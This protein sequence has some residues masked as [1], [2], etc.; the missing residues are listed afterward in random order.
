MP[1]TK[2]TDSVDWREILQLAAVILGGILTANTHMNSESASKLAVDHAQALRAEIDKRASGAD[3]KEE[4][5][6]EKE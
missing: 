6:K 2:K 3:E 4:E 5:A 1:N